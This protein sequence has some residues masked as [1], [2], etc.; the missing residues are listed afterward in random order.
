MRLN[1]RIALIY[2]VV[3]TIIFGVLYP[4]AV[5]GVSQLFFRDKANGQ[6]IYHDGK[7]IGSRLLGQTF[8]SP[9]YFH[10]RPSAAGTGYDAA[11][12]SGSNY[13]P[14][15]ARLV[16]RVKTDTASA[17]SD[18]PGTAVPVDLVTASA[19]GL[20]PHITPAA[21]AFQQARV[22]HERH[23]PSDRVRQLVERHTA[24][25][26]FGFLG[27]PT[28]N[29]LELNLELDQLYPMAKH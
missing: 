6:L 11:N 25:R 3:T 22:A 24:T 14:T 15:S 28:V 29:V 26:Q 2:T 18:M 8:T 5:T 9:D 7:V 13:A 10:S 17:A 20:D 12:S 27:E 16:D 1:F 23:I 4:L 19:S 21:A